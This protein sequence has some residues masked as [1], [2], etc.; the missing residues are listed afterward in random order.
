MKKRNE[1]LGVYDLKESDVF[2]P[3]LERRLHLDYPISKTITCRDDSC[4]VIE[5]ERESS[6]L[7]IRKLTEGECVRLMGF[8]KKDYESMKKAKMSKGQIYKV[9]GD[10]IVVPVLVGIF[11]QLMPISENELKEKIVNYT[12]SLVENTDE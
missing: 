12:D 7:R 2:R 11:G 10:S 9:C 1:Y 6:M 3:T 5:R 8:E 4:C